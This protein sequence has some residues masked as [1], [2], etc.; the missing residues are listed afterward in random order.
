M[1]KPGL[2]EAPPRRQFKDYYGIFRFGKFFGRCTIYQ[3]NSQPRSQRSLSCIM[4]YCFRLLLTFS[5]T[6]AIN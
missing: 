1:Q 4:Q 3:V 2:H 6:R 5:N